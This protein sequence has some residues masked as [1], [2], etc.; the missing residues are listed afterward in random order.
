MAVY[1]SYVGNWRGDLE[2]SVSYPNGGQATIT[3]LCRID[4]KGSG[5]L[6]TAT[7]TAKGGWGS[8]SGSLSGGGWTS[9]GQVRQFGSKAVAT[10]NRTH[11]W[12]YFSYSAQFQYK[13]SSTTSNWYGTGTLS[14]GVRPKDSYTVSYNANGGTGAPANQTKWYGETLTLQAGKPTRTGYK[15]MGWATSATATVATYQ[16]S[17]AYTTN[18]GTTLYAVWKQVVKAK[19]NGEWKDAET[20]VKASGSW[21]KADAMYVK[22]GNEWK[23]I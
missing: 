18:G 2:Q 13:S 15:F 6:S 10:V 23:S 4:R 7:Y 5:N 16:P 17:G 14:V 1:T 11:S 9:S 22:V 8:V 20:Q 19:V 3:L 12:Q 21:H